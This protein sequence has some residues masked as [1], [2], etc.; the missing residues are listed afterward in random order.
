MRQIV[1]KQPCYVMRSVRVLGGMH[2]GVCAKTKR[3]TGKGTRARAG[4]WRVVTG[5]GL[6]P[7]GPNKE[8]KVLSV[9]GRGRPCA[10]PQHTYRFVFI[11]FTHN[12]AALASAHRTL[13]FLPESLS[14]LMW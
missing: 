6:M 7:G 4:T 9:T 8:R 1:K 13:G 12:A 2:A 3:A 14:V 10:P 5:P 11:P